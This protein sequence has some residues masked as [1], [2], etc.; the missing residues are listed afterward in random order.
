MRRSWVWWAGIG[1]VLGAVA[2]EGLLW[3]YSAPVHVT[4]DSQVTGAD[5]EVEPLPDQLDTL[6]G[7]MQRVV[8]RVR[9]PGSEVQRLKGTVTLVPTTASGQ[10]D[11]FAIECGEYSTVEPGETREFAVVFRVDAA[12]LRGSRQIAMQHLFEPAVVRP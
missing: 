1:V 2:I 10:V 3:R 8:F 6:P 5:L 12:G 9:N 4:F 11:I 7:Q